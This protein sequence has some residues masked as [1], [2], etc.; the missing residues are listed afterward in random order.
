MAFLSER[1]GEEVAREKLMT[2]TEK[3]RSALPA[4]QMPKP[5]PSIR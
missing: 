3:F 5:R 1:C 2:I 4:D